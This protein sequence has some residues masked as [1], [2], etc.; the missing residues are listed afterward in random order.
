[1]MWSTTFGTKV[2][3]KK[4]GRP[5]LSDGG[6]KNIQ[7]AVRFNPTEHKE[8][9]DVAGTG[10]VRADDVRLSALQG[11]RMWAPWVK[12]KWTRQQLQGKMVEF[13][14]TTDRSHSEGVGQFEIRSRSGE[15]SISILVASKG[16]PAGKT[17]HYYLLGKAAANKIEI[18]PN[19]EVAPFRLWE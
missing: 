12:S 11:A 14:I 1:M 15:L 17:K 18:N 4:M 8:I 13:K 5:V 19:P 6:A 2:M 16:T 7:L 9:E 10:R 3:R